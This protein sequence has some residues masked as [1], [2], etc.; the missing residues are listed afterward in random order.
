MLYLGLD[1]SLTST[2]VCV[3]ADSKTADTFT[4]SSP[5]NMKGADRLVWVTDALSEIVE[6]YGGSPMFTLAAIEGYAY[7][8]T[9]GRIFQLGELG[10]VIRVWL[11]TH[12]IQFVVPNIKHVKKFTGA[13]ANATK[14]EMGWS[15]LET[16]GFDFRIAKFE[17]KHPAH[18]GM[19]DTHW[20]D[21]EADAYVLANIACLYG[22]AWDIA[23]NNTQLGI[24]ESIVLDPYALLST[25]QHKKLRQEASDV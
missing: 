16:F 13:S 21:D 14:T 4:L 5:K 11:R 23:P 18:W 12:D 15:V 22:G 19:K 10:G 3:L 25:Q 17:A 6:R 1:L 20:K 9:A 24:V 7:G 2:G 8:V